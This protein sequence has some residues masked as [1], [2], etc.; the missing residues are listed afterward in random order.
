MRPIAWSEPIIFPCDVDT[1]RCAQLPVIAAGAQGLSATFTVKQQ[2]NG[3]RHSATLLLVV[4]LTAVQLITSS[5]LC[6]RC[7][8]RLPDSQETSGA[9]TLTEHYH[10]MVVKLDAPPPRI[11]PSFMRQVA[12]AYSDSLSSKPPA[13][14]GYCL[15]RLRYDPACSVPIKQ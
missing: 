11:L 4:D 12:F 10:V 6:G 15:P 5:N 8:L 14:S 9:G 2:L 3:L 13:V 1:V 7:R